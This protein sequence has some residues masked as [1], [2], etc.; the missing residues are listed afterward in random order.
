MSVTSAFVGKEPQLGLRQ[1][2]SPFPNPPRNRQA[3]G[4]LWFWGP[5]PKADCSAATLA[6]IIA[7]GSLSNAIFFLD[8]NVFT[9]ELDISVWNALSRRRILIA[10]TVWK[11]LL[12]W[13]KSPYCNNIVRN[14]VV[15][16][17]REQIRFAN[18][19]IDQSF[20]TEIPPKSSDLPKLGVLFLT[21]DF[22]LHGYD[23]YLRLLALR[24]ALGPIAYSYLR[25]E[26]G[27]APSNDEFLS[28]IQKQFGERAFLLARKGLA[29]SNS[30]NKIND[31]HLVVM[32]ILSAIMRGVETFIITRDR[33]VMEQFFKIL[34]MMTQH[35]RAMLIA[36]RYAAN[37]EATP[38]R[39][40]VLD[41]SDPDALAFS[42]P[43]ILQFETTDREFNF[44]PTKFHF[45][46]IYCLLI[47]DGPNGLRIS[48]CSFCAETEMAKMLL[49]KAWTGG[50]N[51]EKL[52]GRNCVVTASPL[53][54]DNH[55]ICVRI[56]KERV[57]NLGNFGK[58]GVRDFSDALLDN[59]IFTRQ[60]IQ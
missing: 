54:A 23:Y 15:S 46:N 26:L 1:T 16:G 17:I 52:D 2:P 44:L 12:P 29:A 22:K 27:R 50:L 41:R 19:K 32:A 47:G 9:R 37:P 49:T 60:S 56:G 7:D 30:P 31:E 59:E 45:T 57:V 48:T 6:E 58:L 3:I 33:D 40:V 18:N 14:R 4:R 25:R 42:E 28:E 21:E 5:T 13:L 36:D 43:S 55:K 10:P 8:T 35:Y 34:H 20:E 24:K 39:R 11:E 38:F 51:S 53:S